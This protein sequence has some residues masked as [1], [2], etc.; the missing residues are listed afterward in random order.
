[1]GRRGEG[2]TERLL[3]KEMHSE[4]SNQGREGGNAMGIPEAG[5][6]GLAAGVLVCLVR[7]LDAG[8]ARQQDQA[9]LTQLSHPRSPVMLSR[10]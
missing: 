10:L 9:P 7:D 5:S 8:S 1:M 2:G 3:S 4:A 6:E